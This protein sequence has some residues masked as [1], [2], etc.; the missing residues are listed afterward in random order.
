MVLFW[1]RYRSESDGPTII[2]L[3]NIGLSSQV[4]HSRGQGINHIRVFLDSALVV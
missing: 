2:T 3:R 4:L 1:E